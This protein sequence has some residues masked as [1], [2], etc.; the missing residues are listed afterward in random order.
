MPELSKDVVSL[1]TFLLPGFLVA[2]VLYAL[3]SHQKPVKVERIIQALVFT[4]FV[5]A[6]IFIER[7]FLE[8]VGSWHAIRPWNSDSELFASLITALALGL[9]GAYVINTD[10]LYQ[11]LRDRRI[12][13][14]SSQ[15]SEWCMVLSKYK[16]YVVLHFKDDRR[17]FGWP[18]VWPSDS[19]KGHFFIV[20]PVWAHAGSDPIPGVEGILVDVRE[21]KQIEF[22][23]SPEEDS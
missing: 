22:V 14:R 16:L 8:S 17:L 9:I 10:S 5:K 12:S 6:L 2:W 19:E 11:F 7:F 21:I 4:L 15:P 1:L 18:E 13:T 20:S 3:T 23:Q